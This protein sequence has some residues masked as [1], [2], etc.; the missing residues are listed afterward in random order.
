MLTTQTANG[1]KNSWQTPPPSLRTAAH[2]GKGDTKQDAL[3]TAKKCEGSRVYMT[4]NHRPERAPKWRARHSLVAEH[5]FDDID[6]MALPLQ[7][8]LAQSH[9]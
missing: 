7:S 8:T 1:H 5:F 2:T 3:K 9:Q 6:E 4:M